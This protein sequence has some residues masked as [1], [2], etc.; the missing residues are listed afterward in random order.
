M[1]H[2]GLSTEK[3]QQPPDDIQST[4]THPER[5]Q[6]ES[7]AHTQPSGATAPSRASESSPSQRRLEDFARLSGTWFWEMDANLRYCYV[8]DRFKEI[9]GIPESLVLGMADDEIGITEHDAGAWLEH[10]TDLRD[11]RSFRNFIFSRTHPD[12]HTVVVAVNGDALFDQSGILLGYRGTGAEITESKQAEAALQKVKALYAR[13]E[14]LAKIGYWEWDEVAD[15]AAHCSEEM[16]RLHGV[17]VEEYL[18]RSDSWVADLDSVHPDDRDRYEMAIEKYL[19]HPT[20]FEFEY[21]MVSNSGQVHYVREVIAPVF[22][23]DDS[24]VRSIG[25]VQD[26]SE[27]KKAEKLLV[28]A[29]NELEQRVQNRTAELRNSNEALIERER[30]LRQAARIAK[31]G[32]FS[33]DDADGTIDYDNEVTDF[34]GIQTAD[35]NSENI[36]DAFSRVHP[37]DL[38]RVQT[39]HKVS[40]ANGTAADLEY[41]IVRPGGEIRHVHEVSYATDNEDDSIYQGFGILQDITELKIINAELAET[42]ERLHELGAHSREV[43]W[44]VSADWRRVIYISPAYEQVWGRTCQSLLDDA[45]GWIEFVHPDEREF[46][47]AEIQDKVANKDSDPG[48]TEY[49][50]I[51]PDGGVRWILARAYPIRDKEGKITRIAGFGEDITESKAAADALHH[52]QKMDAVGQLTGGVA[53]DFNNLLAVILGNSGLLQ[54]RL[55]AE[56]EL[57]VGEIIRAGKRG[58]VLTRQLLAFSRQQPLRPTATN[59]N[60]LINNLGEL[61]RRTLGTTIEI[62][63]SLA[64]GETRVMVDPALLENAILNL[65]LNARDAMP[66]G[67]TL[68]IRTTEAHVCRSSA[69]N[70]QARDFVHQM[71]IVVQDNGAGMTPD[72]LSHALEPFFTTKETGQGSGLGLPMVYGFAKQSKGDLTIESEQ[73]K[74]TKVTLSLPC[75]HESDSE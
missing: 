22:D 11:G 15:K 8:S 9:T 10:L 2:D 16:A 69:P 6:A 19:S 14:A 13:T 64:P 18:Q 75:M 20:K 37:D 52:A 34:L 48:F 54:G 29:R 21:R 71:S 53:H 63:A 50:I 33:W 74:G 42:E 3:T 40:F 25:Y 59:I 57:L 56:N 7:S 5:L 65:A 43:F 67:G 68:R 41:R 12:G 51:R 27:N 45:A 72:V 73:G 62:D 60:A 1:M 66:Q 38:E 24:L 61:L 32:Y 49:R 17:S 70:P 28:R 35:C 23:R 36:K 30:R 58:A 55:S 44:I 46:V 39:I 26:I 31:L 47:I 4:I